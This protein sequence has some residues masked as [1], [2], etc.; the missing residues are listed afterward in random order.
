MKKIV[1]LLLLLLSLTGCSGNKAEKAIENTTQATEKTTEEDIIE[2]NYDFNDVLDIPNSKLVIDEEGRELLEIELTLDNVNYLRKYKTISREYVDEFGDSE[3]ETIK[4]YYCPLYDHGY[5]LIK[6]YDYASK[7]E[8]E[9][10]STKHPTIIWA[11]VSLLKIK[12]RYV[13]CKLEDYDSF[14]MR[15]TIYY[16]CTSE[17]GVCFATGSAWNED[18]PY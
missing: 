3:T 1:I 16:M 17:D 6:V 11:N 10:K 7:I 18:F 4:G 2:T 5:R 12:G 8:E 13:F 15:E 9:T 14:D